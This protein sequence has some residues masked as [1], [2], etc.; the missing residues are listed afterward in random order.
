MYYTENWLDYFVLRLIKHESMFLFQF[1]VMQHSKECTEKQNHLIATDNSDSSPPNTPCPSPSSHCTPEGGEE[2]EGWKKKGGELMLSHVFTEIKNTFKFFILPSSLNIWTKHF[3]FPT[4]IHYN[5]IFSSSNV[6]ISSIHSL[7]K[8]VSKINQINSAS[9]QTPVRV[10][11][12][13]TNCSISKLLITLKA[14]KTNM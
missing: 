8:I 14:C 12:V 5:S 2:K 7:N 4:G 13:N 9:I 3:C 6:T 11:I 10:Q 1:A